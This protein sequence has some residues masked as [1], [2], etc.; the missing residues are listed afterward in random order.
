MKTIKK[1]KKVVVVETKHQNNKSEGG[2]R[3]GMKGN[4]HFDKIMNNPNAPRLNINEYINMSVGKLKEEIEGMQ[5]N[6][7]ANVGREGKLFGS[8]TNKDIAE[9]LMKKGYEID[10]RNIRLEEPIKDVG[11]YVIEISLSQDVKTNINLLV[12]EGADD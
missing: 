7:Q 11:T 2:S 10:K 1:A 6:I 12:E 9:E 4:N 8:I 5:I 3:K